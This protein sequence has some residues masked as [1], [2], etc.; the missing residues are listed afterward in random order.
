MKVSNDSQRKMIGTENK[1]K[2]TYLGICGGLV[3]SILKWWSSY[4]PAEVHSFLLNVVAKERK[5]EQIEAKNFTFK[6]KLT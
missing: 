6:I 3:V 5:H 4:N 1:T 2:L